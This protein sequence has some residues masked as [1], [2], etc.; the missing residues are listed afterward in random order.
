MA[1]LC[2]INR[3]FPVVLALLLLLVGLAASSAQVNTAPSASLSQLG[4]FTENLGQWNG[5]AKYLAHSPGLDSWITANGVVYDF[6]K[7]APNGQKTLGPNSKLK[8]KRMGHVVRMSFVGSIPSAIVPATELSGKLNFFLGNA[9]GN[10]RTGVRRYLEAT[11]AHIYPGISARYYFDGGA[12]RYD[13]IVAPGADPSRIDMHFDGAI[14]LILLQSGVL[15]IGTSL[16]AVEQRGLLVY[17]GSGTTRKVITSRMIT[18]GANVHFQLGNYD[19]SKALIIDPLIFSTYLGG[20]GGNGDVGNAVAIDSAG[21]T[22][23]AGQTSSTDFP[24]KVGAYQIK[25]ISTS[26]TGFVAKLA[27][28]G[29]SVV[30]CTFLGGSGGSFGDSCNALAL[31]LSNNVVVAGATSSANFPITSGSYQTKSKTFFSTGFVSKLSA[32]G[33]ALLAS[34]YLGGSTSESCTALALDSAGNAYVTGSTTSDD[35]PVTSGAFQAT[36]KNT[37]GLGGPAFVAELSAN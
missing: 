16:G 14:S 6:Y 19:R 32:T 31:D 35:F 27:P 5:Q 9:S 25:D 15:Q 21:N 30:F 4:Y 34:T 36:S 10:W 26:T 2:P 37:S 3:R 23:L 13:L 17:Q 12:A 18:D 7:V 8:F 11:A 1:T 29:R 22:V 28:D 20:S 24:V 33:S